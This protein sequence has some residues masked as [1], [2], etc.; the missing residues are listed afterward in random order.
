MQ[1]SE[2]DSRCSTNG[3]PIVRYPRD[4]PEFWSWVLGKW[5]KEEVVDDSEGEEGRKLERSEMQ[6]S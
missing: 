4:S 1:T 2:L 3:V 5:M 6:H